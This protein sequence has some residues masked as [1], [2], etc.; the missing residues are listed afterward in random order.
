MNRTPL[1][2]A[3]V[4]AT[5]STLLALLLTEP[6]LAHVD[7]QP[8][9]VE[10]STVTELRVELP[11]LRAGA[12]PERLEV[13]AP[14]VEMLASTALGAAEGETLWSVRIRVS[15]TVPAGNLLLVLRG[16][17]AN[18]E[19][20]EVDGSITV[21]PGAEKTPAGSFPW[22]AVVAGAGLALAIAATG[23]VLARRR[24]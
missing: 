21:V 1:R 15:P 6:S 7:V 24:G 10:H 22:V 4:S 17:F 13:E 16:V 3:Y 8:R 9:L 2:R 19:S 18:G 5:V 20:V 12:P 14:G 23:L 11:R